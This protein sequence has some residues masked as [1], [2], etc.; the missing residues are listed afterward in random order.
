MKTT[1]C[2]LTLATILAAPALATAQYI[3]SSKSGIGF[4]PQGSFNEQPI[5]TNE[6]D[7]SVYFGPLANP[8]F[9]T[10]E[11]AGFHAV[12]LPFASFGDGSATSELVWFMQAGAAY[13]VVRGIEVGAFTPPLVLSPRTGTGDL[14]VFITL[15][16][17]IDDV[18]VALRNTVTFPVRSDSFWRWNPGVHALVRFDSGRFEVGS[19]FPMVFVADEVAATLDVPLR[20]AFRV[21]D[22]VF[23]GLETGVNKLD[24]A[25]GENDVFLP[26]GFFAAYSLEAGNHRIDFTGRFHW[27][28]FVWLNAPEGWPDRVLQDTYTISLGAN[29]LFDTSTRKRKR[30]KTKPKPQEAPEQD[31]PKFTPAGDVQG[32]PPRSP[33]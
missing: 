16:S 25:R 19:F 3:G 11:E 22:E 8:K 4:E 27:Q 17:S 21:V 5:A 29:F 33:Q 7:F 15:A 18:D 23:L 14:P 12:R 2:A 31:G 1:L 32:T 10:G 26:L 20:A 24:I 13:G 28:S 9:G 6:R 30:K